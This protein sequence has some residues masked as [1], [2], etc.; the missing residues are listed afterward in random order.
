MQDISKNEISLLLIIFKNPEKE[1]NANSISKQLDIS[2]M[3]ALKILK[4][5]EKENILV[6]KKLGNAF[7]YKFN[8][9]SEYAINYIKFLL[10][11]EVEHLNG[12]VKIW[13][14]ELKKI[15]SAQCIILFGSVLRKYKDAN[16]IDVLFVTDKNKFNLLK[17]EIENI[18]LLNIKKIHPIYQLKKDFLNN[19]ENYDKIILESIKGIVIVGD[20]FLIGALNE[21][22]G[23]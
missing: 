20:D 6:S 4:R 16:D 1:F 23:K 19:L 12:Y 7:F 15:K 13:T 5:L 17:K 21:S 2:S 10:K 14:N 22:F 9:K 8:F 11:K 18:N 3:G